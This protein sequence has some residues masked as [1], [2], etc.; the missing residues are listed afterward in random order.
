MTERFEATYG[1]MSF[2]VERDPEVGWYLYVYRG[3]K[4]THDYLQ[5]TREAALESASE[6]FGV[7]RSAW[8]LSSN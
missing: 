1:D 8:S 5:D 7:P 4:C 3:A 6:L 2:V